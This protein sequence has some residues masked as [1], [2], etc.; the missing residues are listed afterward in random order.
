MFQTSERES[1]KKR[2]H[3]CSEETDQ[4]TGLLS[5]SAITSTRISHFDTISPVLS[6]SSSSSTPRTSLK[7][8]KQQI[9]R[10]LKFRK[11]TVSIAVLAI[12]CLFYCLLSIKRSANSPSQPAIEFFENTPRV[13]IRSAL[14]LA[15][16]KRRIVTDTIAPSEFLHQLNQ[17][18]LVQLHPELVSV[19]E[20]ISTSC[21]RQMK[22]RLVKERVFDPF[23]CD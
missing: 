23:N 18:G 11:L 20:P 6:D 19:L 17:T 15:K 4:S 21:F 5:P 22:Q 14:E 16:Q 7:A 12:F 9:D 3:F 8:N 2:I 13:D 10:Q 1:V